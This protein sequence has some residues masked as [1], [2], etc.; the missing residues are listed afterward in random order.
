M[1]ANREDGGASVTLKLPAE[2]SRHLAPRPGPRD[3]S[4]AGRRSCIGPHRLLT[5]LR[6]RGVDDGRVHTTQPRKER[7]RPSLNS[8]R[9]VAAAIAVAIG[10][11]G[12]IRRLP[13]SAPQA[14][15]RPTP[16]VQ[17]GRR[18]LCLVGTASGRSP[19]ASGSG[20]PRRSG[21]GLREHRRA[22]PTSH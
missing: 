11:S 20:R 17:A 9:R 7:V 13:W 4:S 1:A 22:T 16:T 12:V 8:C 14:A 10:L 6:W 19:D 18:R 21:Q 2:P 15:P 3:R 5:I